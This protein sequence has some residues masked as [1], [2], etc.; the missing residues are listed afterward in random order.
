MSGP[1]ASYGSDAS[2]NSTWPQESQ[3]L[4][5]APGPEDSPSPSVSVESPNSNDSEDQPA[6]TVQPA[7]SGTHVNSGNRSAKKNGEKKP[8]LACLF[9]RGRKIACGPP[10]PGGDDHTC[11]QCHRRQLKCEYPAESRRGMRRK[12]SVSDLDGDS[13]ETKRS[14]SKSQRT[15][16]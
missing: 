16:R 3:R 14:S 8:P 9:C 13:P 10:V 5:L 11:N 1:S 6:V 4:S 15:R 7:P 2:F 12:R